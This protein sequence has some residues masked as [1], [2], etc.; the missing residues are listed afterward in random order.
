M[1]DSSEI[2]TEPVAEQPDTVSVEVSAAMERLIERLV[3]LEGRQRQLERLFE[4]QQAALQK[5][6]E[7]LQAH[8]AQWDAVAAKIVPPVSE[9]VN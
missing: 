9:V 8:Q 4:T 6:H 7:V 1:Q 2:L 3:A 5:A